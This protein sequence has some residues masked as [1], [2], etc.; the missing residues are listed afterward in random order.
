MTDDITS[1]DEFIT[2]KALAE[3]SLSSDSAG[4]TLVAMVGEGQTRGRAALLD[5]DACVNQNFAAVVPRETV[6]SIFLFHLL[7]SQYE[8]LRHWS[9]GTNQ[10]ALNCKLVGLF[11]VHVPG[12]IDSGG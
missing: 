7:E 5:I 6:D 2:E 11:Q 10:H 12:L 4:G 9:Q 8:A 3:C 1:S